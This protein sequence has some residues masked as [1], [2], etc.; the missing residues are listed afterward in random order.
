MRDTQAGQTCFKAP[1][2]KGETTRENVTMSVVL[3]GRGPSWATQ[4]G[5]GDLGARGGNLLL[6]ALMLRLVLPA[7]SH[8][9][10]GKAENA[11]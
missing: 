4:R 11:L 6:D 5:R 10:Q 3:P 9:A 1:P 8:E 7:P 2:G